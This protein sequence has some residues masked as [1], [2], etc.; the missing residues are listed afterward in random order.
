MYICSANAVCTCCHCCSDTAATAATA[1]TAVCL[2]M[3]IGRQGWQNNNN[4]VSRHSSGPRGS[5]SHRG[6]EEKN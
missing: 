2:K 3:A 1:A 5:Q 4:T 6:P